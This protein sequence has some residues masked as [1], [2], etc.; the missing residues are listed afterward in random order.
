MTMTC[1]RETC[2]PN[3]CTSHLSEQRLEGTSGTQ[4]RLVLYD[5]LVKS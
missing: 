5:Y 2:A 4:L 1:H 3:S